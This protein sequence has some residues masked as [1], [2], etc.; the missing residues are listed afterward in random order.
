MTKAL[1]FF[2]REQEDLAEHYRNKSFDRKASEQ[3][4]KEAGVL[5]DVFR[6]IHAKFEEYLAAN[7][8]VLDR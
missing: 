2:V 3:E 1:E 5:C 8:T 4:R 7:T 6:G